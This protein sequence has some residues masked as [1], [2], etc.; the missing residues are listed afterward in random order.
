MSEKL[1][2]NRQLILICT[3]SDCRK[4]GSFKLR[5]TARKCLKKLGAKERALVLTT[6]C[7]DHCDDGPIVHL[8]ASGEWLAKTSPKAL[9]KAIDRA[10]K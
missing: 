8:P 9:K 2:E 6:S 7:T 10:L 1:D 3:G 4:A 5:K